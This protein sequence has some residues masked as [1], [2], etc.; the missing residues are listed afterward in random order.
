M[1]EFKEILREIERLEPGDQ[2]VLATVVD[3]RGSS[4]RL[5][6]A[7][8]LLSKRGATFGTVSG[9]CLEA[10]VAERAKQ[11]FRTGAPQIFT[12]D[13]TQNENSVFSLNMGCRGV[14]R[15]LL[16]TVDRESSTL[17]ALRRAFE[18]RIPQ[19]VA[20][21]I[22]MGAAGDA[23]IG[24]RIVCDESRWFECDH[25]PELEKDFSAMLA[26]KTAFEHRV[27]ATAKGELEFALEMIEPPVALLIF[28]AGADAVPLVE[29]GAS[30]G[31]QITVIDHRP[32]F[33]TAER[34]PLEAPNLILHNGENL[35]EKIKTDNRTATVVMT[36]N[37]ERD[38]EIL[39]HLLASEAFYVGALGPRRRTDNLLRELTE[40]GESFAPE[41]LK[42]LFAPVGL[43]L[44]ADTPESI[45]LSIAAEI[46]AVLKAQ[47][48]GFLRD[49]KGSIYNRRPADIDS[50]PI[51]ATAN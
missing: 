23:P 43:N 1:K 13:T 45:A 15:I 10:D 16:E 41:N 44:G 24:A 6:G 29:I 19:F 38:R 28:G 42:K 40:S 22:G 26:N 3:V 35:T 18:A 32:A 25:L 2:A 9:G 37:Y 51:P 12:Y 8:M 47:T 33:L 46:Q 39:R 11:V 5:P 48:G 50:A 17:A 7:R 21:L 30:Q 14:I 31:W 4:Y 34:F 27:Y 20:T 49:K 36:H